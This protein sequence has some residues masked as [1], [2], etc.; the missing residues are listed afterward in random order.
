[1][2]QLAAFQRF[3]RLS[4]QPVFAKDFK[5]SVKYTRVSSKEQ[6]EKT[7]SLDFQGKA[8]DEFAEKNG[9]TIRESFGGKFESAK[10]DGRKEFQRMLDYIR[11]KKGRIGY[12]LIYTTSRFSRTGGGAI[13]LAAD[14]RQKYGVQVLAVT[15]PADTT[16]PTGQFQ[17]NIQLLVSQ[18][19]NELRRQATMAGSKEHLERGIWCLK[20]PMGYDAIEINGKREIVINKTGELLRKAF[21]WKLKGMKNEKILEKLSTLGLHIYKQKLSMIFSNPFYAGI[22]VNKMLNGKVVK[23]QHPA[24]VSE[25]DFLAVNEIR[26]AAKG[27]FGVY[28]QKEREEIPLKVF[29]QCDKCSGR[30]TGYVVKTKG[31]YYYKCRTQGC[32]CNINAQKMNE[33]FAAF[34]NRYTL[35]EELIAPLLRDMKAV[36]EQRNKGEGSQLKELN[37]N[38]KTIEGY[39]NNI[40]ESFYVRREM[41]GDTYQRLKL[42]YL[43]QKDTILQEIQQCEK[44]S[45]NL[46][47]YL[48]TATKLSLELATTWASSPVTKKEALQKLIFPEGVYYN[49]EKQSFRTEKVNSVFAL[50]AGLT[51]VSRGNKKGRS[52][53]STTSSSQVG[54]T[55]FEPATP[56]SQTRCATGLRYFPIR[57]FAENR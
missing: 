33:Q 38:L 42:K 54:K 56:W 35:R 37:Q 21:Q 39:L 23:G 19:D 8:I 30:F 26:A 57:L 31:L 41:E 36:Y 24:L 12:I 50:F 13:K 6:Q 3:A 51:S 34:L 47:N 17:Q 55:G 32:K 10:T 27:K 43:R 1:M 7:L 5:E 53:I 18:Y 14:L 40:D 29:T 16:T 46:S 9:F 44:M 28:H 20:P 52:S 2:T 22:I 11:Q 15:Q 49:L 45:S 4:D 25:Q 48:E